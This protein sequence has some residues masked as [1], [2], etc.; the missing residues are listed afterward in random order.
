MANPTPAKTLI[1]VAPELLQALPPAE[2]PGGAEVI[3]LNLGQDPITQISTILAARKEKQ[4]EV[5]RIISP[6]EPG[7]ILLAGHRIT[8]TSLKTRTTELG[9]WAEALVPGADILL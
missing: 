5:L 1:I 6:G 7:S 4:Y 3:K 8:A 9:K 2:L